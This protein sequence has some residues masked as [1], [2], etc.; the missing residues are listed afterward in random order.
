M[1]RL[2]LG[3]A[4]AALMAA[5]AA[6]AQDYQTETLAE[7]LDNPWGMAFM[8][9]GQDILITSRNGAL[10]LWRAGQGDVVE[11]SGA[12]E[13]DTNGQG[14]LLDVALSPNFD[15]DDLV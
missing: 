4:A 6:A 2:M 9:N 15:E 13:V 10:M 3:C 11:I 14:G 5:G 7:G 1:R 8:P 12:P